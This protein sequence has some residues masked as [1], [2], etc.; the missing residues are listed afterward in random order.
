MVLVNIICNYTL[1]F[2][3][4]GFPHMGIAGAAIGSTIAELVATLF[5]YVYIRRKASYK[6]YNLF[7][8]IHFQ[9]G[10]LKRIMKMSFWTMIQALLSLST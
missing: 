8:S 1:I 10:L 4:F 7:S 5:L 6:K 9:W 2:G 3:K